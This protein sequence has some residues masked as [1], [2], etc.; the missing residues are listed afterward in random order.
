MILY[1]TPKRDVH[2]SINQ[3]IKHIDFSKSNVM[4]PSFNQ[5]YAFAKPTYSYNY[6]VSRLE[7]ELSTLLE[8]KTPLLTDGPNGPEIPSNR[9]S[10]R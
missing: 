5:T 8:D 2:Q 4:P 3:W 1:S 9:P 6:L 10:K 7:Q